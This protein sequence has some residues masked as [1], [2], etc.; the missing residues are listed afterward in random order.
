[1]D[2]ALDDFI[3]WYQALDD[4][5]AEDVT[6]SVDLLADLG[7]KLGFP[8]SSAI[9]GCKVALRE[10]RVQ[11]GGRPVRV[12][13]GFDPKRQAVLLLGGDKTGDDRFYEVFVPRAER[14]FAEYLKER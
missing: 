2:I 6:A 8:H 4:D 9:R 14:L 5:T 1:M 13:Y 11:S 7:V 10:L 12:F 3:A